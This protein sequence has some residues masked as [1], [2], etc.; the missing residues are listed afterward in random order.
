MA[1]E[2]VLNRCVIEWVMI[3]GRLSL[4]N[5]LIQ[6]RAAKCVK[7]MKLAKWWLMI[8]IQVFA[9]STHVDAVIL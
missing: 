9:A 2:Y 6:L 4:G 8:Q 3:A 7:T 1:I 5:L